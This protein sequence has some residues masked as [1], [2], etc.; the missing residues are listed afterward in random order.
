[1]QRATVGVVQRQ[2]AAVGHAVTE[3]DGLLGVAPSGPTR[4]ARSGLLHG[5]R[6][7]VDAPEAGD[8]EEARAWAAAGTGRPYAVDRVPAG[9]GQSG[10]SCSSRPICR[11]IIGMRGV[12][13][14]YDPKLPNP[15][16]EGMG[17][18]VC[19]LVASA[20]TPRAS[21]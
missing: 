5:H 19:R 8:A 9:G 11:L 16:G 20:F 7:A 2:R 4:W 18:H 14:E 13:V 12:L 10:F 3:G 1:V 21:T 15:L 17:Q 6:D